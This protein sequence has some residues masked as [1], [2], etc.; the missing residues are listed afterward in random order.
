MGGAIAM[1]LATL[2]ALGALAWL[3]AA[4][5]RSI[6]DERSQGRSV[7]REF[8]LGLVLMLLFFATWAAHG[9]A[10]WQTYTDQQR[11]HGES[12]EVGDFISE[13]G[14][15]T[16]ENW[17][18]EFLQLFS[19]VV[20]SALYIHKGS[21]ESKDGDEKLEASLRRIEERLGTLPAHA[22]PASEPDGW[23]LPSTQLD[24]EDTGSAAAA[25]T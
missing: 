5:I 7:F 3:I 4:M 18:S 11:E 2:I 14:Q 20:L 16:L 10:E 23:K 13:F 1:G 9:V 15:A 17:Q 21:A 12:T 6:Q 25:K 24:A 8:G 19:F 22:I